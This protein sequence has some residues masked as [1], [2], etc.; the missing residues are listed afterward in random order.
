MAVKWGRW[1]DHLPLWIALGAAASSGIY[2]PWELVVMALPLIAAIGVE[3]LRWD[4]GRHHRWLEIGALLFFLGDLALGRGLFP[5]AIHTL[6]VLAG[7]RLVLPKEPTQRRQL[8][9]I[10]FLLFLTT[11]IGTT[12]I[13]FLVWTLIWCGA[14]TRGRSAS[15]VPAT[16][17][18]RL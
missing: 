16:R 4:V 18:M 6:F 17:S 7:V 1:I 10:G 5:V 2:E 14:A 12:D 9:L 15:R 13:T 3:G 8:L 11:A